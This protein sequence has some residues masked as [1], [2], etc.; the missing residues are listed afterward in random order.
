[1]HS[2]QPLPDYIGV[3]LLLLLCLTV[4]ACSEQKSTP[5]GGGKKLSGGNSSKAGSS[6]GGKKGTQRKDDEWEEVSRKYVSR[7]ASAFLTHLSYAMLIGSVRIMCSCDS[8]YNK[9]L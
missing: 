4:N 9:F 3:L 1:M 8:V 2:M 7:H 5:G 6:G